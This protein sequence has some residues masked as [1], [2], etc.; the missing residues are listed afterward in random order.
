[1]IAPS[2]RM[3]SLASLYP[4][5]TQKT[6]FSD[7]GLHKIEDVESALVHSVQEVYTEYPPNPRRD[8]WQTRI[9]PA[10]KKVP[11]RRIVKMCD[12]QLSRR[13]I[14]ELRAERRRPQPRNQ[15]MIA[16]WLQDLGLI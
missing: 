4:A 14:I 6:T 8:E 1:M 5:K 11:L 12:G 7:D 15:E 13:E 10:L 9:L 3:M 16:V 2:A